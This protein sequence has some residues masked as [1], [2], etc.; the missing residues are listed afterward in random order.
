MT[1]IELRK[2]ARN[3][4][5]EGKSK[6]E[7][8]EELK[9]MSSIKPEDIAKI[10][11]ETVSQDAKSSNIMPQVLIL[12]LLGA[13][14]T[15]QALVIANNYRINAG[16]VWPAIRC[17]VGLVLF[18]GI[19]FYAAEAYRSARIWMG[20]GLF[21]FFF[22]ILYLGFEWFDLIDMAVY[23]GVILLSFYLEKKL[24]PPYGLVKELYQNRNGEDRLRYLIRFE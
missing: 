19:V 15:I 23:S 10:V 9:L 22:L 7:T 4:I 1:K 5:C 13:Y 24:F 14:I 17:A 18:L 2:R 12:M 16:I 6:Q 21:R 8:Y 20:L 3:M 11:Q